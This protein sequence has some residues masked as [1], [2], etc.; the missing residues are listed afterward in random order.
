MTAQT[1]TAPALLLPHREAMDRQPAASQEALTARRQLCE[2]FFRENTRQVSSGSMPEIDWYDHYRAV[3]KRSKD[4]PLPLE[5][6]RRI[7]GSFV[8]TIQDID[9]KKFY[10]GLLPLMTEASS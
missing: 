5:T 6:F 9:E 7:A 8:P 2:W 10:M 1:E 3:C 4:E